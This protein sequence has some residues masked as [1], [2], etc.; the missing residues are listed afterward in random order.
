M[1]KNKS[2]IIGSVLALISILILFLLPIL[3]S[4]N[5]SFLWRVGAA[6]YLI[7]AFAG[8]PIAC[9]GSI[10]VASSLPA[11]GKGSCDSGLIIFGIIISV[12][13]IVAWV[14]SLVGGYYL[15]VL[16]LYFAPVSIVAGLFG[17]WMIGMG[18]PGKKMVETDEQG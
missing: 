7:A 4:I 12:L 6:L 15:P 10:L 1:R 5:D 9:A 11:I 14:F 18:L 16:T 17:G 3:F 8:F 13:G 2:L